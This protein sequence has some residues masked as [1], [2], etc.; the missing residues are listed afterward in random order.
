ML[1]LNFTGKGQS[2]WDTYTH[3]YPSR[4]AGES[5]GDDAAKSYYK[6]K[7]DIKALKQLG[8]N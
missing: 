2:V 1:F 7:E 5:N 8:V 3:E 6:Y 4:I